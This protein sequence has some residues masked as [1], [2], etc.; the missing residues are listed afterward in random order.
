MGG[1]A[2]N[3]RHRVEILASVKTKDAVGSAKAV[4][5]TQFRI[6]TEI[7]HDFRPTDRFSPTSATHTY[8]D[9]TWFITRRGRTFTRQLRLRHQN[10]T[11]EILDIQDEAREGD[12]DI[13]LLCREVTP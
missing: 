12:Y 9:R 3:Y 6:W 7:R 11:Y 13:K 8:E 10:R 1:R 4:W 5:A 2:G